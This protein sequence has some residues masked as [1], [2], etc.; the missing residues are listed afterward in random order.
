VAYLHSFHPHF[1]IVALTATPGRTTEKVQEVVD[2]LHI[3]RVEIR[4]A[5]APEIQRYMFKKVWL[6]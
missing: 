5:E 3:S 1:R 6:Q 2:N 4:E